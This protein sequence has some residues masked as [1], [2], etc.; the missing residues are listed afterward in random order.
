MLLSCLR[1]SNEKAYKLVHRKHRKLGALTDGPDAVFE[2]IK[3]RRMK[4]TET[5]VEKQMRVLA[6]YEA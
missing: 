3:N 6:E 5:P 1:G 4:F 2:E